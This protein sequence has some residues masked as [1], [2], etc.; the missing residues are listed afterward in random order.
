MA[1]TAKKVL[2]V[3]VVDDSA[4]DNQAICDVLIA[5]GCEAFS[6]FSGD[7]S[8]K[9]AQALK[10]DVVLM[11]VVM[12]GMNGFQACKLLCKMEETKNIPVIMVSNKYQQTDVL[13]AQKQGA[14]GYFDKPLDEKLL[15]AKIR[16]LTSGF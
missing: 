10:P 9:K 5:S 13:W 7:E 6:A 15:M 11:D 16:E 8:L 4:T 14:K 2:K 3:L 1:N 12:P